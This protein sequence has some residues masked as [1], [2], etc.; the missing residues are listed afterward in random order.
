[1]YWDNAERLAETGAMHVQCDRDD[2]VG[3]DDVEDS[4]EDW[5]DAVRAPNHFDAVID[6]SSY[7]RSDTRSA[8]AEFGSRIKLYVFI[9][10]DSVYEVCTDP[11]PEMGPT[12]S[13]SGHGPA[14]AWRASVEGDAHRPP[15]HSEA[16]RR[17]RR[18]DRYGHGKLVS[19][20]E[21]ERA[22]Q[23]NG[24]QFLSLRLADVLG[25]RDNTGR[26]I[27]YI[28]W[29]IAAHT[30]RS[31]VPGI[32][33]PHNLMRR[34][35]S[36]VSASDVA[37]VIT[38]AVSGELPDSALNT[39]YNLAHPPILLQD[40]ITTMAASIGVGVRFVEV[41]TAKEATAFLPSVERGPVCTD[42]A[43]RALGW[44][45]TPLDAA[46]QRTC[47]FYVAAIA[48]GQKEARDAVAELVDDLDIVDVSEEDVWH[49]VHSFA[50]SK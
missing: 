11:A 2:L 23:K 40:L 36:L 37:R 24:F 30:C 33:I 4:R 22:A 34:P 17:L 21:I 19:E 15:A 3:G 26:W 8:L 13:P 14:A 18:A 43:Q 45:P 35:L 29:I 31:T 47:H 44:A 7:T 50:R 5:P 16:R 20:R 46:L 10:S 39:A 9:S 41:P 6:F 1:V 32:H 49:A 38:S 28:V 42:L 25:P 12:G 27:E 48:S